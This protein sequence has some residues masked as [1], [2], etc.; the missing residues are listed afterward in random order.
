MPLR[1]W[2]WPLL[3]HTYH[4]R[5]LTTKTNVRLKS[6]IYLYNYFKFFLK[7]H[8]PAFQNH[9]YPRRFQ[10]RSRA[11]ICRLRGE[12]WLKLQRNNPTAHRRGLDSNHRWCSTSHRLE[13]SHTQSQLQSSPLRLTTCQKTRKRTVW[14]IFCPRNPIFVHQ[15]QQKLDLPHAVTVTH[16]GL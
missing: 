12:A 3:V 5:F 1:F 13:T 15:V 8:E 2:T 4:S 9:M 6:A 11:K 14:A 7:F 10:G 16:E